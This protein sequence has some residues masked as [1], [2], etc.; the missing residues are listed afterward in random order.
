[1][2]GAHHPVPVNAE[3]IVRTGGGGGWGDPIERD[4][5]TVRADVEE[6]FV[7]RAVAREHYGVVLRDDLS[8]DHAATE[9]T[10]NAIRSQQGSEKPRTMG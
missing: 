3:V 7:S 9:R 4:P 8:I 10:R 5:A 6:E 2:G 1:M